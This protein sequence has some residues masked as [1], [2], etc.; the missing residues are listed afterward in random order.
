[1]GFH[2]HIYG[3]WPARSACLDQKTDVRPDPIYIARWCVAIHI[4]PLQN[5]PSIALKVFQ[6]H[7]FF[8]CMSVTRNQLG[9]IH[10]RPALERR[11]IVYR[12]NR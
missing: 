10:A 1:V 4:T 9:S 7:P 11:F 8:I 5:N 2:P 3:R 6:N 12:R